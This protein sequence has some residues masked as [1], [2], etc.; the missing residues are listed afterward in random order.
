MILYNLSNGDVTKAEGVYQ[1]E[2]NYVFA[3]RKTQQMLSQ[4][5]RKHSEI[6]RGKNK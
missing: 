6:M 5:Q 4:F 2:W 1:T 3:Y